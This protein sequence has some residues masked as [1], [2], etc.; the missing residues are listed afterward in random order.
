MAR[1]WADFGPRYGIPPDPRST[2][3][4]GARRREGGPSVS[5]SAQ[6][7]AEGRDPPQETNYPMG[8]GRHVRSYRMSILSTGCFARFSKISMDLDRF[9][10]LMWV[11]FG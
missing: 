4:A 10:V 6:P 2:I 8:G 5:T 9:G 1:F 11:D 7:V 3:S